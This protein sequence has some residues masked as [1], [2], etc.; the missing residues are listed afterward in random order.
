T[1]WQVPSGR[2]GCGE[3]AGSA[4][5]ANDSLAVRIANVKPGRRLAATLDATTTDPRTP[6]LGLAACL[7]ARAGAARPCARHLALDRF[8][9][10]G[11]HARAV[12]DDRRIRPHRA[13]RRA[14]RGGP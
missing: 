3:G 11:L 9:G 2:V 14:E 7:R 5:R 13:R 4:D 8:A 10:P 1:P 6:P 12:G